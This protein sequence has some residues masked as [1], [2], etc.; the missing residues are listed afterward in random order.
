MRW[1][2]RDGAW[3]VGNDIYA[4]SV[5]VGGSVAAI[6]AAKAELTQR[7]HDLAAAKARDEE[8]RQE[9]ILIERGTQVSVDPTIPYEEAEFAIGG[10]QA[11]P[12]MPLPP[13]SRRVW[14]R[15]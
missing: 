7:D 12:E 9:R 1:W 5:F 14:R 8:L 6:E 2:P 13:P 10:N 4:R 3:A 11:I 15:S